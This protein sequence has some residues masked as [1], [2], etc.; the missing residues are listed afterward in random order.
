MTKVTFSILIST[1]N[2]KDDL[3][4]TL[5]KIQYLL[6]REDVTCVVFDDG[7]TDGTTEFI[8]E[9]FPQIIL[10]TNK[11]SKGYLYCRNKMLNETTADFAISLDDDAHFVTEK[12]LEIIESCFAKNEKTGLLGFRVFW[13]TANPNST[14]TNEDI[15]RMKSFVGCAHVWRMQAW[16]EIRNYPEWFVFYGE[17]DFASYELLK[18]KWEIYYLPE[19]LVNHRVD[20]SGR[21]NNKDYAL[22]LQRS[23]RSGWYLYFLFYPI[24]KIPRK[25][26]Y[27]IWI[28]LKGKVFKGDFKALKAL[29]FALFNVLFLFPKIMKN[30]NRLSMEE[31]REYQNL[32]NAK[33][34]WKPEK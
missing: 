33:I 26:L 9:N 1:K 31:Y 5:Q 6:D 29:V 18:K 30:A 32:E 7:S 22:R 20:I 16:H 4:F 23:L 14:Y 24:A 8:K 11:I 13:S 10:H 28:Q 2:R 27:S 21:K 15:V 12:P 34:F 17:E 19:V 3:G 25:M